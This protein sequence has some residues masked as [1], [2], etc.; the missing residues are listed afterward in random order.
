MKRLLSL[1]MAISLLCVG[2]ANNVDPNEAIDSI[3]RAINSG[4]VAHARQLADNFCKNN[5]PIDSMPVEQLCRLA[6]AYAQLSETAADYEENLAQAMV[7]LNAAMNRDYDA[8]VD[9][10]QHTLP[11][12]YVYSM[13]LSEMFRQQFVNGIDSTEIYLDSLSDY[14]Q[15]LAELTDNNE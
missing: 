7:C 12:K 3:D 11:D 15:P 14:Y 4:D 1:G 9:Y 13:M 5:E 10:L 6:L 2:C 8:T